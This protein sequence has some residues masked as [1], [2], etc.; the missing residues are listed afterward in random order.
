MP[1]GMLLGGASASG[2]QQF[3]SAMSKAGKAAGAVAGAVAG[4]GPRLVNAILRMRIPAGKAAPA[5]P[6]GPVL[7]QQGLNLMEFCKAFNERSK[8]IKDG[9]VMPVVLT[10][11][12]D[13]TFY[14]QLKAPPSSYFLKLCA[15][16]EKGASKPGHETVGK[17]SLKQVY[18][19]ACMKAR[20]HDLQQVPLEGICRSIIGTAKSMGIEVVNA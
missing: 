7:G 16:I 8:P 1:A 4:K 15:G 3:A 12:K 9:V 6:V 2:V 10:S 5:P 14:F 18:E 17:V 20:E 11:F 19:I 13:K